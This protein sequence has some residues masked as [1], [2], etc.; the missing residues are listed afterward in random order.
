M[1]PAALDP[2]CTHM[3]DDAVPLRSNHGTNIQYMNF[4]ALSYHVNEQLPQWL[5][6][7]DDNR[8][9]VITYKGNGFYSK[10]CSC[11]PDLPLGPRPQVPHGIQHCSSG[12]VDHSFLW[13]E[14]CSTSPLRKCS[15]LG[16]ARWQGSVQTCYSGLISYPSHLTIT[17]Q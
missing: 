10:S 11:H 2:E 1:R 5:Q 12:Q 17:G 7:N 6:G 9:W 13:A 16:H 4:P 14:L 3:H 8:L 15:S